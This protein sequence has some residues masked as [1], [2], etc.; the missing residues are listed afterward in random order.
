[1][2]ACYVNDEKNTQVLI[3][4]I[5]IIIIIVVVVVVVVSIMSLLQ[6][7]GTN[8]VLPVICTAYVEMLLWLY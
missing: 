4:I 7:C 2:I 8:C 6:E 1:M 5:I 3:I